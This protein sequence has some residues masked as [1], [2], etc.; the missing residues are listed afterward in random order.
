MNVQLH[1]MLDCKCDAQWIAVRENNIREKGR[2]ISGQESN[3]ETE[4]YGLD[5]SSYNSEHNFFCCY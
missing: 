5:S 1:S 3:K 2:L 4:N